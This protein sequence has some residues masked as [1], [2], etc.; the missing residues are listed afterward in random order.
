M[1][2]VGSLTEESLYSCI[3][4]LAGRK[5]RRN[6]RKFK[7]RQIKLANF[8]LCGLDVSFFGKGGGKTEDPVSKCGGGSR[9]KVPGSCEDDSVSK[10]GGT[11]ET[12]ASSKGGGGF[13]K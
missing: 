3:K 8:S 12:F 1:K 2:V 5:L 7:A 10:G 9:K 11:I 13:G 4:L 6:Q